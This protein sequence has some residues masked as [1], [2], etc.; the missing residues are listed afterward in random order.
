MS[1]RWIPSIKQLSLVSSSHSDINP[2]SCLLTLALEAPGQF[3]QRQFDKQA[4]KAV[5]GVHVNTMSTIENLKEKDLPLSKTLSSNSAL[6]R[7]LNK[8]YE[9]KRTLEIALSGRHVG[10]RL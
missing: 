8:E 4:H 7:D 1:E 2:T 3:Y 5:S 10:T 9:L 6:Q